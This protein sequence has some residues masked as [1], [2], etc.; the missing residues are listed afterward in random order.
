MHDV[1]SHKMDNSSAVRK[2]IKKKYKKG[3]IN[4]TKQGNELQY[5]Q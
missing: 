4:V 5:S 1:K 3:K 2:T